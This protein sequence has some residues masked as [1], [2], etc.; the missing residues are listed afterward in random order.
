M[1][2]YS[3]AY[4]GFLREGS[5]QLKQNWIFGMHDAKLRAV[6]RGVWGHAPL[7]IFLKWCNFVRFEGYF[8]PLSRYK[9]S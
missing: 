9:S 2:G 7:K 1:H 5:A 8:Q 4:A 6:A 3:G